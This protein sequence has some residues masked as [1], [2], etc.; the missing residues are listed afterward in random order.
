MV[1]DEELVSKFGA[2]LSAL[3]NLIA[4]LEQRHKEE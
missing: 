2:A 4:A 1:S 3:D